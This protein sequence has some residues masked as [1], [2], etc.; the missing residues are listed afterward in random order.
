LQPAIETAL[1]NYTPELRQDTGL[2]VAI[3][4]S[5]MNSRYSEADFLAAMTALEHLIYV[6][7]ARNPQGRIVGKGDFRNKIQPVIEDALRT[8]LASLG[9]RSGD[10]RVAEMVENLGKINERS[11][12]DH[13]EAFLAYH[14]VP[15]DKPKEVIKILVKLR[16]DIVHRG[17]ASPENQPHLEKLLAVLRELLARVFLTLLRY[18]GPY[19]SYLAGCEIKQF[20]IESTS[21]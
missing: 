13:L 15:V 14:G 20:P 10:S 2:D 12:R 17:Q 19:F 5:L 7:S 1:N 21:T 16:N 9:I 18:R 3:A 4:W 6:Y 11:L 8:A